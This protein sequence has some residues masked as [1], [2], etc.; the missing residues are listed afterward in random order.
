VC[1]NKS[2][3]RFREAGS[4]PLAMFRVSAEVLEGLEMALEEG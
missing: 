1:W 2:R 4:I 3:Q